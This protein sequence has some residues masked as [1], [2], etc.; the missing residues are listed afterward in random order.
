LYG[1]AKGIVMVAEEAKEYVIKIIELLNNKNHYNLISEKGKI[2]AKK[3]YSL[4]KVECDLFNVI[5]LVKEI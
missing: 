1:E 2:F 4:D 3:N 5:N